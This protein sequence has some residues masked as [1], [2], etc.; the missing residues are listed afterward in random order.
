ME[1]IRFAAKTVRQIEGT[2][3]ATCTA[4]PGCLGTGPTRRSALQALRDAMQ[5]FLEPALKHCSQAEISVLVVASG[6][7]TS[8][9]SERKP[10][11][12]TVGRMERSPL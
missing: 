9:G 5:D 3:V 7:Q 12:V 11:A 1:T 6:A 4:A 2:Y 8:P 10:G